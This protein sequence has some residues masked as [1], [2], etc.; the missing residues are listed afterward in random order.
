MIYIY[1]INRYTLYTT[2]QNIKIRDLK[3][4]YHPP[5]FLSIRK[6]CSHP[7]FDSQSDARAHFSPHLIIQ[8]TRLFIHRLLMCLSYKA[9][10]LRREAILLNYETL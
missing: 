8:K 1:L 4:I 2:H 3:P 9:T 5:C 10:V 7:S 6:K